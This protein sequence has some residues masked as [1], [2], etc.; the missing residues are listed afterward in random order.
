MVLT[1]VPTMA[2]LHLDHEVQT[3]DDVACVGAAVAHC[4]RDA[5]H[6]RDDALQGFARR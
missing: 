5:C 2:V 1:M 3:H 4:L 6:K